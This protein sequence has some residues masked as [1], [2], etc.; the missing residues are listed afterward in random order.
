MR[1]FSQVCA[2]S[3]FAA[4]ASAVE[5]RQAVAERTQ[6]EAEK[7]DERMIA[8]NP[9][10][11]ATPVVA[12]MKKLSSLTLFKSELVKSSY[13]SCCRPRIPKCC[14]F[15][16]ENLWQ[17][18]EPMRSVI[19]PPTAVQPAMY[20][21]K[22][23]DSIDFDMPPMSSGQPFCHEFTVTGGP[24]SSATLEVMVY[25]RPPCA[26]KKDRLCLTNALGKEW[27]TMLDEGYNHLCLDLGELDLLNGLSTL[28]VRA[29]HHSTMDYLR[30][31][32]M[33]CNV[34]PVPP[35]ASQQFSFTNN[36]NAAGGGVPPFTLAGTG[37]ASYS[38]GAPMGTALNFGLNDQ[39]LTQPNHASQQGGHALTLAVSVYFEEGEPVLL[40]M[41][42]VEKYGSYRWMVNPGSPWT[43]QHVHL[44]PGFG[45]L[46]FAQDRA[47]HPG[48]NVPVNKWLCLAVSIDVQPAA[49]TTTLKY[50]LNGALWGPPSV[51][52]EVYNMDGTADLAINRPGTL[53]HWE[54][55][56]DAFQMWQS[57]VHAKDINA[58]CNCH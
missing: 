25:S 18:G 46:R 53:S 1:A 41:P 2:L 21:P 26:A 52:N 27:C 5:R 4:T 37:T 58:W 42:I 47:S 45:D 38:T 44:G 28:L 16:T 57:V 50:Y 11:K 55:K 40:G 9:L 17:F 29:A 48:F 34:V 23:F 19:P 10:P 22:C 39:H 33:Y 43:Y 31:H 35:P 54:G 20:N 30:L 6:A 24:V 7:V 49:G 51:Y 32:T 8:R 56:L 15:G 3:L 13:K 14:M 12:E 36:L